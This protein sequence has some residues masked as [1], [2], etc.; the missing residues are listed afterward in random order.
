MACHVIHTHAQSDGTLSYQDL[1]TQIEK[2]YHM[3]KIPTQHLDSAIMKLMSDGSVIR[4]NNRLSLTSVKR[5]EIK[6]QNKYSED[7]ESRLKETITRVLKENISSITQN[8]IDLIVANLSLV[9]GTTFA[10]YGSVAAKAIAEGTNG[11]LELKKRPAFQEVYETKILNIL[12]KHYHKELDI[13][14]NQ[15]FSNPP[16]DFSEYLYS[17]AQSYVYLEILNLDPELKKMQNVSW[18]QKIIYLDTNTLLS[19]IFERSTLHASIYTL[20]RQTRELGAQIFITEYTAREYERVLQDQKEKY[21]RFKMRTKFADTYN[22]SNSDNQFF[23]TYVDQIIKN[24][25]LTIDQFS[26]KYEEYDKLIKNQYQIDIE[27]IDKSIDLESEDASKLKV[28]IVHQRIHKY[29]EVVNHDAYNIL[30]VHSIR[31][32][33]SS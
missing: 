31:A 9:L 26:K 17:M 14:F 30:R 18:A 8:H 27:P 32:N 25:R 13:V 23:S 7:I 1:V 22:E 19:L 15:L 3:I 16:E 33:S 4:A 12:P 5:N 10:N 21:R 28:H 2:D 29:P 11:I 6:K 24:P 20:I